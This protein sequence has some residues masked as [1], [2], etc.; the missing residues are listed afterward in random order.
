MYLI[1]DVSRWLDERKL[2][3]AE[4][5]STAVGQF[6]AD[7]RAEAAPLPDHLDGISSSVAAIELFHSPAAAA[8]ARYGKPRLDWARGNTNSSLYKSA[9]YC[10]SPATTGRVGHLDGGISA[11]AARIPHRG[12]HEALRCRR[13][14]RPRNF[15]LG[16]CRC[17]TSATYASGSPPAERSSSTMCPISSTA[18]S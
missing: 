7:W 6:L 5:S 12:H 1:A 8:T 4:F 14:R 16:R 9:L 10:G 13:A 18:A 11:A 15:V 2:E 3:P 17:R